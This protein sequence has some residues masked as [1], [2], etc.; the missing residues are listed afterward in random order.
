MLRQR[1]YKNMGRKAKQI[2]YDNRLLYYTDGKDTIRVS[3]DKTNNLYVLFHN[4]KRLLARKE[5]S[6]MSDEFF[7]VV[8]REK[9]E[10][11]E[12]AQRKISMAS[13]EEITKGLSPDRNVKLIIDEDGSVTASDIIQLTPKE[14]C[15]LFA[16]IYRKDPL[17][18][19]VLSGIPQLSKL[20]T[21]D[22]K[23]HIKKSDVTLDDLLN[24]YINRIEQDGTM[25][26]KNKIRYIRDAQNWWGEFTAIIRIKSGSKNNLLSDVTKEQII[27]YI[28]EICAVASQPNYKDKCSWLS[29]NQ[30]RT[31]KAPYP[32]KTWIRKRKD[33]ITTIL[34]NYIE[35]KYLDSN[36]YEY[37][38]IDDVL[39]IIKSSKKLKKIAVK[40]KQKPKAVNVETFH[41]LFNTSN[42]RWKSYH[43]LS[44]NCGFTFEELS[45]LEKQD[46]NLDRGE[47]IQN[48]P[49]TGELRC[50][51][52]HSLACKLLSEY[53][54]K[55]NHNNN[56]PYF[57]LGRSNEKL[58]ADSC[59]DY[60]RELRKEAGIDSKIKFKNFR[61]C[62]PTVATQKGCSSIQIRLLM[63][64]LS[65]NDKVNSPNPCSK[66]TKIGGSIDRFDEFKG[67]V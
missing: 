33:T 59:R 8:D 49:K 2:Y 10:T 25:K 46:V 20:S 5:L 30:K 23:F 52:L 18:A 64:G 12:V 38:L 37:K 15:N 50:S 17:K 28:N 47:I 16:D 36:N 13:D 6:D 53:N 14:I 39:S 1:R 63:L 32:K 45:D 4:K 56:S 58:N 41:K 9:F 35:E 51:K 48:R 54:E 55:Y 21:L 62:A 66:Q 24:C 67:F 31:I 11:V 42:L 26:E 27:K 3:E 40:P 19:E 43:A 7:K 61:K 29:E 44:V 22:F 60:F 57:F 34:M 65:K